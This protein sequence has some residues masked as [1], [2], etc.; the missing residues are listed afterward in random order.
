MPDPELSE[1][2]VGREGASG[3]I[4]STICSEAD[5]NTRV[6][7]EQTTRGGARRLPGR[8]AVPGH[9]SNA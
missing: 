7:R 5:S 6:M 4:R 2:F 3:F 1:R 9:G 8:Q